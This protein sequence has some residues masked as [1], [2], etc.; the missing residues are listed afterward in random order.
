MDKFVESLNL[1]Y[2]CRYENLDFKPEIKFKRNNNPVLESFTEIKVYTPDKK[3]DNAWKSV[4]SSVNVSESVSSSVNDSESDY[5]NKTKILIPLFKI[6]FNDE[7]DELFKGHE[8]LFVPM[9]AWIGG[10]LVIKKYPED[11]FEQH[12]LQACINYAIN[13]T[14]AEQEISFQDLGIPLNIEGLNCDEH[15]DEMNK[16][17]KYIEELYDFKYASVI[18]YEKV[19]SPSD[20]GIKHDLLVPGISNHKVYSMDEWLQD[21][22]FLKIPKYKLGHGLV[23]SSDGVVISKKPA[24]KISISSIRRI[25]KTKKECFIEISNDQSPNTSHYRYRIVNEQIEFTLSNKEPTEMF[26]KAIDRALKSKAEYRYE[27]LTDVFLEYGHVICQKF[28]MGKVID[29]LS[30]KNKL[31]TEGKKNNLPNEEKKNNLPNEEKKNNLPNEEKKNNLPNEEKK[32][33]LPNE[34]K[35]N[36]LPNEDGSAISEEK[37]TYVNDSWSTD[38]SKKD[39]KSWHVVDKYEMIPIT[40]LLNEATQQ[41][42]ENIIENKSEEEDKNCEITRFK[43]EKIQNE[44]SYF[45][46]AG[47]AETIDEKKPDKKLKNHIINFVNRIKKGEYYLDNTFECVIKEEPE[48]DNHSEINGY[49]KISKTGAN[50]ADVPKIKIHEEQTVNANDSVKSDAS[51]INN[52]EEQQ[53]KVI[54][55]KVSSTKLSTQV[56]EKIIENNNP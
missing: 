39:L 36:N 10:F 9:I 50:N 8:N 6:K 7:N 41:E 51:E 47:T 33:N 20:K 56:V 24:K 26:E 12:V 21:N 40:N 17:H 32:N 42:I 16:L 34:E 49:A 48:E 55:K 13:N 38:L 14:Q 22:V 29:A 35:K 27:K 43:H 54:T 23:I 45:K 30:N 11:H 37:N 1:N 19:I 5:L 46:F 2:M 28:T 52:Y 53:H 18:A 4:S 3:A 44:K 25:R 15:I 31:P